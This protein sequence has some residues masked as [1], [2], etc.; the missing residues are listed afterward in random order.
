MPLHLYSAEGLLSF[1]AQ[2]HGVFVLIVRVAT[3][4]NASSCRHVYDS[5]LSGGRTQYVNAKK[6]TLQTLKRQLTVA[7]NYV[8][9]IK[10][11]QK[12]LKIIRIDNKKN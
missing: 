1:V 2:I 7:G 12:C 6:S 4:V 9:T 5:F 8:F 10:M 3:F 11:Q